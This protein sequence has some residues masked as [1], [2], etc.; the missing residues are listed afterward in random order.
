MTQDR[1]LPSGNSHAQNEPD[2]PPVISL[3]LAILAASTASILIR[4]AQ[5]D[6]P[7]LVIAVYR[8]TIASLILTPVLLSRYR[9]ELQAMTKHELLLT[10]VSGVFL[11]IHF[12]TWITS[13]EYTSVASSVVLVQ[14]APLFVALLSP[15]FLGERPSRFIFVG[16]IL[17]LFGSLIIGLS[18]ACNWDEGLHCP[19]IASFFS[20]SAMKGDL[21]ALAG[22]AAGAAYI[23]I[24][25][26]VRSTVTLLP[27]ITVTYGVASGVLIILMIQAGYEPFGYSSQTY[28][29]FL[30]LALLPQLFAHSTYNWA[31]RYLSAALVSISQLGE[32]V[33]STILAYL[34]LRE[35]PTALRIVGAVI[36]LTGIAVASLRP[37]SNVRRIKPVNSID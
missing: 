1:T 15:L 34:F 12:A 11:S 6:A 8:L 28:L 10:L 22:A 29:W 32:P 25:R 31:L 21:L 9:D 4:F 20:G 35:I 16:L 30:L 18:D 37:S 14:T 17:A 19:P 7:S 36:I 26:R 5:A 23:M 3:A 24:G 27:Y 13:L 2:I 33:A